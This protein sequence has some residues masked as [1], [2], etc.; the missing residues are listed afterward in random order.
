MEPTI[1]T[2]DEHKMTF[3]KLGQDHTPKHT[4]QHS[5]KRSSKGT[6]GHSRKRAQQ[7]PLNT[8]DSRR[9]AEIRA[10]A[11]VEVQLGEPLRDDCPALGVEF[12]ALP[13]GAFTAYMCKSGLV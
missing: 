10:I 1:I 5:G 4:K 9:A 7:G 3:N 13:V 6:D 12:D 2:S 8:M 11:A